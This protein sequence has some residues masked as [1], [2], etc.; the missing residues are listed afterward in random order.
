MSARRARRVALRAAACAWAAP[1][2]AL[3][4]AAGVL[5][6][7]GG[8]SVQWVGGTAEFHGGRLAALAC[9]SGFGAMTL[10]HVILGLDTAQLH[11]L[12]AHESA[13][14][15]QCERW[16]PF[17]LPA[18]ALASLWQAAR[19]RRAHADNPFERQARAQAAARAEAH[20]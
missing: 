19:G 13:H 10:G 15:R 7:A 4:L 1:N 5:V 16:G 18:Y 12:R 2:T 17:F 14:V 3:G 20:F 8:G 11:A 9:R 6:L